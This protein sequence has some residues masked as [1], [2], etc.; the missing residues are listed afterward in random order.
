M[1]DVASFGT[2]RLARTACTSFGTSHQ[3]DRES[4]LSGRQWCSHRDSC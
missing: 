2:D 1:L 4:P 3:C